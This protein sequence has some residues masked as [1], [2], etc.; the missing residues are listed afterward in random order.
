MKA[1]GLQA[2]FLDD[3]EMPI[4]RDAVRELLEITARATRTED[5]ALRM[6]ARRKLSAL[7]PISW[8]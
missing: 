4:S 3:P 7:G 1:V 5:L 8:C 2:Q 6:A